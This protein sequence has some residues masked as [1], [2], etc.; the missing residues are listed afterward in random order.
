MTVITNLAF[1]RGPYKD[2]QGFKQDVIKS[3]KHN[4]PFSTVF[5]IENEEKEPGMPDLLSMERE[6]PAFFTEIK[7]ADKNGIIEFQ[8]TQPLFYRRHSKMR[9]QILAWDTPRN[10]CVHIHPEEVIAAKSL[11]IKLP[12][13]IKVMTAEDGEENAG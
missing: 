13:E 12:D 8:K 9:I 10:R 3:F 5:E 6:R 2:E 7:C 4:T 11:K 1:V